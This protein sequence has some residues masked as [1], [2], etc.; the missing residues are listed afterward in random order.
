MVTA[1]DVAKVLVNYQ[2]QEDSDLSNLKLQKLVWYCLGFCG[3]LTGKKLFDDEIKAW[4]HGPV[5]P[6]LYHELKK[7]GRNP[8]ELDVNPDLEE[9]FEKEQLEVIYEV[10]EVFGKYSAWK[11]RNMTHEEAPWLNHESTAGTIPFN[12]I[13]E[14]FKTRLN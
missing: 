13:V 10:A 7:F 1:L 14:Y 3:A 4:E 6:T 2:N 9:K 11:L 12:E 8:V 5:V